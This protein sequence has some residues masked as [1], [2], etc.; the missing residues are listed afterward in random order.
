MSRHKPVKQLVISSNI[1]LLLLLLLS[2]VTAFKI[3]FLTGNNLQAAT[4]VLKM[5]IMPKKIE[6]CVKEI[7][8]NK[9]AFYPIYHQTSKE[10]R[11]EVSA[12]WMRVLINHK[13]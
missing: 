2:E 13:L 12:D 10:S 4:C 9:K 3:S 5:A 8:A 7:R 11:V 1:I 6:I